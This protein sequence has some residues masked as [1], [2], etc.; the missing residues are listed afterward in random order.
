MRTRRWRRADVLVYAALAACGGSGA[1]EPELTGTVT[2]KVNP[3]SAL[4]AFIGSSTTATLTF[5]RLPGY[6]DPVVL[7]AT[8]D[9]QPPGITVT[10]NPS[11][12]TGSA[13]SSTM[14]LAAASTASPASGNITVYLPDLSGTPSQLP[15]AFRVARAQI[16][17]SRAGTGA[18]TVTSSPAGINCGTACTSPFAFGTNVTLTAT[19]AAGSAFAGWNGGNCSGTSPCSV[20]VTSSPTITATFNSTAQSFSFGVSPTAASLPQGGATTAAVNITRVNGFA[21]AVTLATS[22]APTWLTV[23]ATP[24][25]VTDNTATINVAAASSLA[26]GNYPITITAS[27]SGVPTQTATLAVQI[28]PGAGGSGNVTFSFATC[29]PSEVP[30]W[31]GAQSGSGAWTRVTAGPNNTFTFAAGATGGFA[32]VTSASGGFATNVMYGNRADITALALGNPCGGQHEAAGTTKLAGTVAAVPANTVDVAVGSAVTEFPITQGSNFT[33][34]G[35]PAGQRDLVATAT[36]LNPNGS[37]GIAKI[38]L[39]HNVA[40][41]GTIPTLNFNGPESFVPPFFPTTSTNTG[42]DQVS[43]SLSLVT[44]NGATGPYYENDAGPNGGL[45]YPAIPDSILQPGDLHALTIFAASNQADFRLVTLLK[46]SAA[47]ETV[48]FGPVLNRPT[49]TSLGTSPYLRLHTQLASQSEYNAGANAEF[50]QG[51]NSVTVTT[52]AGYTGTAP[53]N[54]SIDVPDLSSAG[55][56]ANWGLK[57]GSAVDW[58][59]IAAG[60]D[61]LPLLGA[62]VADGQRAIIASVSST[63][64]AFSIARRRTRLWPARR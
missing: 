41:T 14:T 52:T 42:T 30:I 54:W 44:A 11:T 33:M 16:F 26:A 60:G 53:P 1:G 12:L 57:S 43:A 22:G 21:G 6:T 47:A 3:Q 8:I 27:G 55:Y 31:F 4:V 20:A 49:V 48:T 39:R 37:R 23:S 36:N 51:N 2:V 9:G 56:D 17:V 18:G 19:P 13:L 61:L 5:T 25:S 38:I 29:D 15:I 59:V 34:A 28:T 35:V 7:N 46:H 24:A 58:S 50:D 45:G 62:T 63:S 32:W 64:S 40:Y 10:F